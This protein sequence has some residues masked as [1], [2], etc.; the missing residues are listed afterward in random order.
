MKKKKEKK[1]EEDQFSSHKRWASI[2][3][4]FKYSQMARKDKMRGT[5]EEQLLDQLLKDLSNPQQS[6]SLKIVLLVFL[7]EN[8]RF[9][10]EEVKR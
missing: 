10:F 2:I 4:A 9:F 8:V 3:Q 1:M 6:D 5:T 7:Q